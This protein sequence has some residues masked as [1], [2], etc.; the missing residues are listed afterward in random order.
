MLM[1]YIYLC[2][3][4][5][6]IPGAYV[7]VC[8]DMHRRTCAHMCVY[9]YMHAYIERERQRDIVRDRERQ[10]ERARASERKKEKEREREIDRLTLRNLYVQR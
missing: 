10:T 2:Y 5:Y 6:Y 4:S 8:V 9:I 3:I 1:Y 7:Y